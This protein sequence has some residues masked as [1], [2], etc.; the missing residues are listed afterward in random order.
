[1]RVRASGLRNQLA[2]RLGRLKLAKLTALHVEA[3][4]AELHKDGVGP[5]AVRSAAD[6]LSI[7]LNYAVWVKM[8]QT[9]D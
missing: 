7:A 5:F 6:L 8:L 2:P 3:F 9:R 1:M 4:Y